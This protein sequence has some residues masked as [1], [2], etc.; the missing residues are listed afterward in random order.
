MIYQ[1]LTVIY[2]EASFL[3]YEKKECF[4]ASLYFGNVEG[5]D[6]KSPSWLRRKFVDLYDS[7]SWLESWETNFQLQTWVSFVN[8]CTVG[9]L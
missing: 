3:K 1:S 5:L 8:S 2:N 6:R 4:G 7:K 9:S